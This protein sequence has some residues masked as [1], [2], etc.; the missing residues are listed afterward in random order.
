MFEYEY[1]ECGVSG[2]TKK[3]MTGKYKLIGLRSVQMIAYNFYNTSGKTEK[4]VLKY[5][6]NSTLLIA[7]GAAFQYEQICIS[8]Y[9]CCDY[10]T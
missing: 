4:N 9:N 8:Y 5:N 6:Y 3:Q 1:I 10:T 7:R 2:S